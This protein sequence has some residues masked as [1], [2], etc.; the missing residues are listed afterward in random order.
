MNQ[1]SWLNRHPHLRP[2]AEF[3]AQIELA[4]ADLPV[5]AAGIPHWGSYEC[6]YRM[7]IPLLRSRRAAIR[8]E[9][10]EAMIVSLIENMASRPLPNN[11]TNE[12]RAL[13]AKICH[14]RPRYQLVETLLDEYEIAPENAGLLRYLGWTALARYLR[15]VIKA[16]A[17]WRDEDRW[18]RSFCPTCGS[19][20]TMAQ[21]VG[22]EP[23]RLRLL[24][25]SYCGTCWRYRRITCPFC[26]NGDD[27]RLESITI[28]GEVGLRIDYCSFC[29]SYLKTYVGQGAEALF[30]AD[31]TSLHLDI[32]ASD[33]GLKRRAASLY[34]F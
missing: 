4:A 5:S 10:A 11:L 22:S 6:D 17:S 7:G 34:E 1:E 3:Q 24:S 25:C 13:A 14:A 15:S 16:F 20:P 32:V 21:L 23:E 26:E 33:R 28:E 12:I 18:L 9:P 27:H 30:L 19:L 2:L 31:W 29:R 8:L